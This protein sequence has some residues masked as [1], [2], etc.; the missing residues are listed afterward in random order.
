MMKKI[1]EK[2]NILLFYINVNVIMKGKYFIYVLVI[3][4]IYFLMI[5]WIFLVWYF[6]GEFEC[7][8]EVL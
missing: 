7:I 2:K 5:D 3:I 6:G 8:G 4:F 1:D